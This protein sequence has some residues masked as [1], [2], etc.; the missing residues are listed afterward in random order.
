MPRIY[1]PVVD[2]NI[3]FGGADF[4]NGVAALTSGTD[5]TYWAAEGYAVDDSKHALT[6]LDELTTDQITRLA[7]YFSVT[8]GEDDTKQDI[9]RAIESAFS[10][11]AMAALTIASVEGSTSGKTAVT[12][13]PSTGTL[14][15]KIADAAL[16]P[17]YGDVPD[18]NWIAFTSGAEI[19]ATTGKF[20]TVVKIV[21]GVI[22]AIGSDEIASK[23]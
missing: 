10:T 19:T 6:L 2:H 1:S 5:T 7:P 16:A 23:A 14:K 11:T 12:S 13:N 9:V 4:I 17:L 15:Y 22:V 20:I 3:T 21:D 8:V 18:S